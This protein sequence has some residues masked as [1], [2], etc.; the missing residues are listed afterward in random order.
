MLTVCTTLLSRPRTYWAREG[1]A[2]KRYTTARVRAALQRRR[3]AGWVA[4]MNPD[5]PR[6]ERVTL[7]R[8]GHPLA[9]AAREYAGGQR[10]FDRKTLEVALGQ[11][12]DTAKG[13]KDLARAGFGLLRRDGDRVELRAADPRL[14]LLVNRARL[15]PQ[16]RGCDEHRALEAVL[17]L[18]PK[19]RR[20]RPANDDRR[21]RAAEILH[22]DWLIDP[23]DLLA[24]RPFVRL[25]SLWTWGS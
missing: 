24:C 4:A 8:L 11:G 5:G 13:A 6:H 25:R 19:A 7:L 3:R 22:E 12:L 1:G 14:A 18:P 9:F 20:R 15:G 16:R 23:D 10:W 17:A 2:R 21:E